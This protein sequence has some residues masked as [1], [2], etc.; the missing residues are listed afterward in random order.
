VP[1]RY[2]KN[3]AE[4][5]RSWVKGSVEGVIIAE[6]IV[7][8]TKTYLQAAIIC[9]MVII[10]EI[11]KTSCNI[12]NKNATPVVRINVDKKLKYWSKDQKGSIISDP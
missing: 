4:A 1:T 3:N 7:V 9:L 6:S 8:S 12:G 10:P 2:R 11:P 5:S